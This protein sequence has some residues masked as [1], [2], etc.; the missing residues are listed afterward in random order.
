MINTT[1]TKPVA[2]RVGKMAREQETRAQNI[3]RATPASPPEMEQSD[4]TEAPASTSASQTKAAL[5]L[6]LLQRSQE[7]ALDE[8]V[9]ATG[10][11]PHTTRAALTGLRKKGHVIAKQ[12]VDGVT[13]YTITPEASA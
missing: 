8:L 2:K 5:V 9:V 3:D 11:L 10:W 7:A 1:A 12:K 6:G 13:R 4:Q